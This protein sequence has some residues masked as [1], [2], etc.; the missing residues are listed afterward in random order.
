M[1]VIFTVGGYL[2]IEALPDTWRDDDQRIVVDEIVGVFVSVLWLPL[3]ATNIILAFVLFRL[4]DIFKPLGI[5]K[6][7][8]IKTSWAVLVDDMVAGVYSNITIRLLTILL[9]WT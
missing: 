3:T 6:F 4:Y 1:L 8:N 5:R 2:A 9:P 7:D